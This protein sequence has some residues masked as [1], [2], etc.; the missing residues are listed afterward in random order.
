MSEVSIALSDTGHGVPQELR[1]KIFHGRYSTRSGGGL[2]LSRSREIL[3]RWGGE[4]ELAEAGTDQST[5]F[6]VKLL[7]APV[8]TGVKARRASA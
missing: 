7:A 4:V 6:I 3:T 1:E 8:G 2:G 5:T